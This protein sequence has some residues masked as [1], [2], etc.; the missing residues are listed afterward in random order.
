MRDQRGLQLPADRVDTTMRTEFRGKSEYAV[1]Q[2]GKRV[3]L[4]TP[5]GLTGRGQQVYQRP[6]IT[7]EVPAIQE[8]TNPRIIEQMLS[9]YLSPKERA[10]NGDAE[11]AGG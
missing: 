4:R 1:T 8:G 6:E 5:Q 9:S 11:T 7:V 3:R 10:R 2:S